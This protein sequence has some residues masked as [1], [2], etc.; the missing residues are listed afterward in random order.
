[1][2]K[3]WNAGIMAGIIFLASCGASTK[4]DDNS[5]SGKKAQLETLKG[6]QTK[7]T[8]EIQKLEDEIGK[9]DTSEAKKEKTK[10]VALDTVAPSSFTHFIDLQGKI[11]AQDIAYVTPRGSGGQVKELYIR[12]GDMVK[13][14]EL[15]LK[16]DDALIKR[17]IDQSRPQLENAKTL[18][19]KQKNLW[20]QQIGTEVQLLNYKTQ[21]ESLERQMAIYNEQLSYT[22]VYAEMPGIVE[23]MNVRVGEMFNASMNQIKIV[24]TSNLKALVQVP[25]N[26]LDKVSIGTN[27]QV[28]LAEINN[29]TIYTKVTASGRLID[30]N[31]RSFWVEAKIPNDKDL[32]PNQV[33]MV[34]IQDYT[35]SHAIVAPVNI[36]QTDEKGKYILVA[37]KEGNRLLA[38]KRAVQIGQ[39]YNDKIEIKSGLKAGDV[40]ITDGFQGLYDGQ[41]ITTAI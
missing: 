24:N 4:S 20:D 6:Q 12:K 23:D 18:Y 27:V 8:T 37:V 15:L 32:H 17:Q 14:G 2:Q 31:T 40:I 16:L 36:L 11:D 30:P 5:L 28:I 35:T 1:M 9:L 41:A 38:R 3:L 22:N 33:A 26:Y 25:E 7:L 21:V 39:L 34:K 19:Q 13:K 10:L 29:K